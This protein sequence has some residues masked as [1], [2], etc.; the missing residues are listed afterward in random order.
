MVVCITITVMI[1]MMRVVTSA[2]MLEIIT[3][4]MTV[5]IIRTVTVQSI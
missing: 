3:G 2:A 1:T 5:A 4:V